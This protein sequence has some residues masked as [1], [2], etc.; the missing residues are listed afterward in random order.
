M[1]Q[2]DE[3]LFVLFFMRIGRCFHCELSGTKVVHPFSH[4]YLGQSFEFEEMARGEHSM[5]NNELVGDGGLRT[6]FQDTSEDDCIYF[7]PAWDADLSARLND[8]AKREL[9][10]EDE[11]SSRAKRRMVKEVARTMAAFIDS[12]ETQMDASMG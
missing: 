11:A 4:A 6:V 2:F 7:D 5:T 10:G 12:K 1:R 8:D 3:L 9:E